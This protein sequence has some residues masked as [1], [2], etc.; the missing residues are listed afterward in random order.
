MNPLISIIIPTY[1]RAHLLR[2]T[3]DSVLAQTYANWECIIIDD[4][5]TDNTFEVVSNYI[6]KDSRFK[7]LVR[8]IERIKGAST[9][10][11]IGLENAKG[12]FIQFL[13]SDDLLSG[14]KL[15]DQITILAKYGDHAIA[16]C[17]WGRFNA[18][19]SLNLRNIYN[20]Y[21]NF[22]LGI[23]LLLNFGEHSEF[24]PLMVYLVP[25][26]TIELSGKWDESLSNNDDGE[27]FTRVLLSASKIIFV[28]TTSV[29]YRGDSYDVKLSSFDTKDK[30]L[31]AIQSWK[32][33][34]IHIFESK[35][36]KNT[37]YVENAKNY[38]FNQIK[39]NDYSIVFSNI[40]FF[41]NQILKKK[42]FN[43]LIR[44]LF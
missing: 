32:L 6:K 10:R 33:I 12:E 18:I 4:G 1:N 34:E 22:N 2:E 40:F 13:D 16:T 36:L 24:F 9:C 20:S 28:E 38:I 41:K 39:K 19:T 15:F 21:K 23:D 42:Y 31:S 3:L 17:K 30:I 25:K 27:F 29:F 14:N 7:Y 44:K 35:G 11:N 26:K 8:P 43:R 5:S 37:L